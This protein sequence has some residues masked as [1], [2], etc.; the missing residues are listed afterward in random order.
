MQTA[1]LG[2]LLLGIPFL[3]RIRKVYPACEINVICREG[4]SSFFQDLKIADFCFEIQK[5][6]SESYKAVQEKLGP[7]SWDFIFCPHESVRSARL[8]HGLRASKKIG[9]KTFWNYFIFSNRVSRDL[10]LPEA[11]RQLSLLQDFDPEL[12]AWIAEYKAKNPIGGLS[13]IPEWASMEVGSLEQTSKAQVRQVCIFPGSVWPT[14]EWTRDGFSFVASTLTKSGYQ[15]LWMGGSGEKDLCKR[16]EGEVPG[17]VSRAGQTTLA[18]SL[19]TV[20][21]SRFVIVNDSAG[22]HLASLAGIPCVSIFGPTVLELGY[23]PWNS[24]AQVVQNNNIGCRPCGKHG[25]RRCPLGTHACM[26]SISATQVLAAID[27]LSL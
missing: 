6:N 25:H 7:V 10:K 24:K 1:F 23:R 15:V 17:S 22:Q 16:L 26:K 11:L 4:L 5:G 8:V 14:K 9:F 21:Q 20:R 18:E 3:K 19:Q 27:R 12:K 13:P 2:D